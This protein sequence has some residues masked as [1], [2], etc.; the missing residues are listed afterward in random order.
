MFAELFARTS[1]A[2]RG[3]GGSMHISDLSLGI[4][5]A[6]GIVGAGAPIAVGAAFA[7]RYQRADRVSVSFFGDGASNQGALFEAAN[8][9]ALWR[10]PCVL[11]CE[12]NGYAEFTAQRFH[13]AVGDIADRASGWGMPGVVVDGMVAAEVWSAATVAVDRA[14]AGDGPTLLEAKTYRFYDHVGIKGMRIAY[15]TQR[16]VDAWVARDP[17]EAIEA[18]LVSEGILTSQEARS[19]HETAQA[20]AEAAV[21][22]AEAGP[23]PEADDLL[24]DVYTEVS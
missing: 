21:A 19:V 5:G 4:L 14:R 20:E 15:R 12:N 7:N 22:A 24:R 3:K 16:E 6:N 11:V 23:L 13:Q 1:G 17:I 10:L 9:A 18:T 2:C 8:M